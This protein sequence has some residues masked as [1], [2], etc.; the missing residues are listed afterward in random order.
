MHGP[1][2]TYANV[3]STAAV[4]LALSGG[5][6]AAVSLSRNSVR[7]AHIAPGQVKAADIAR[8][9]VTGA[10]VRD[11]SIGPADL[12]VA[13]ER[14]PAG[15]AGPAGAPGPQGPPGAAGADA[16]AGGP[17]PAA[18]VFLVEDEEVDPGVEY[19]SFAGEDYDQ[20]GLHDPGDPTRLR[21]PEAGIYEVV[22][23]VWWGPHANDNPGYRFVE[24]VRERGAALVGYDVKQGLDASSYE[25]DVTQTV[26]GTITLEAG[27]TIR[28]RVS[29]S[30]GVGGQIVEIQGGTAALGRTSLAMHRVA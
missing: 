20:G 29:H 3:M 18:G 7:S 9:A 27:D 24:V 26:A 1:R 28:V 12:R 15:P 5:A 14:G 6:Y 17:T 2:L 13:P 22:V 21:A 11:G 16:P 4:F 10:K 8:G 30:F 25:E 23:F 19:L